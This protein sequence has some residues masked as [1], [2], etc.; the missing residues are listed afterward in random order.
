MNGINL[1]S[2]A[3]ALVIAILAVLLF[4]LV[5]EVIGDECR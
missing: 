5:G 4:V 1:N 3:G 2:I